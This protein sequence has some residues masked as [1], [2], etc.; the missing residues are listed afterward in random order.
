ME[1]ISVAVR[2]D[3]T[4]IEEFAAKELAAY[5][6]AM[7]DEKIGVVHS[8]P[9]NAVH[10]GSLPDWVSSEE[11]AL[12]LDDLSRLHNDGFIIRS[13]G[14]AVVIQGKTPR[15][16]LYGVYDYLRMLGARWYFPGREHEFVPKRHEIILKDVNA[17]EFPDMDHRSVVIHCGNSALRDWIDFAAKTKLNAIHLHSDECI[18]QM[19]DLL[20]ARGL[21]FG[22]RRHIFGETYSSDDE[23]GLESNGRILLDYI[24]SL[25]P[26]LND[27]FLWPADR[28][29]ELRD[30]EQGQ[31]SLSDVVL[32]FTN[33]MLKTIRTIKPTARMS[34]LAYW[35]TWDVPEVSQPADG[36]FLELAPIHRCFSHAIADPACSINAKEVLPVIEKLLRIFDPAESHVLGYWLDASLFGRG[37]YKDL[38][39]RLPQM[40]ETIRQDLEYYKSKGISN[41]S[42]FAVG[43]DK[44]YFSG[45]ASPTLFQYPEL[46][47]NTEADLKSELVNFCEN[48]YGDGSLVEVFQMKEQLEPKD[49]GSDNW[50]TIAGRFSHSASIVK[51]IRRNATDDTQI[52]RLDKLMRELR[53]ME[54]WAGGMSKP[55]AKSL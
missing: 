34:F 15:A 6:G 11:K 13:I 50:G 41:I 52:L 7:T 36:V 42:T 12:I 20:A 48:Y 45:F 53:H 33:E 18:H 26:Q 29:L 4:Q 25:P 35:S 47:W 19:P 16:T 22:L 49:I 21:D 44:E 10:V 5:A 55:D 14:G 37:R 17:M 8:S 39:G 38:S 2:D 1:N 40:G 23:D 43:L 28:V 32:T 54:S 3:A 51:D 27:F 9:E 24:R 46:L 31:L 30:T